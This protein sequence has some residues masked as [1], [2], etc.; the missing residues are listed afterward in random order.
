MPEW[1]IRG[2][3]SPVI[4]RLLIYG[5]SPIDVEYVVSV[6]ERT[7]DLRSLEKLWL[8]EWEKK[9]DAY[10]AIGEEARQNS[11]PDTAREL[12]F[13]AAQCLYAAF[14]INFSDATEKQRAYA[15]FAEYYGRSIRHEEPR[16]EKIEIPLGQGA[17]LP[18]YFHRPAGDTVRACA[19]VYSGLGSCKEEMHLLCRPLVRRGVAAF[20]ADYPGNGEA[21]FER[22]LNCS[23][24][25]LENSFGRIID[26]LE[27][28]PGCEGARFGSY[29]L[30]MGGGYAH[31]AAA[32]DP[33]YRFCVTL[34]P[35]F[36]GQVGADAT[37]QWM[38]RGKWYDLQTGG[39]APEAF[40]T[41]M[42]GLEQ[43][44]LDCPFLFIHGTHD[45]WMSLERASA[46]F[47]RARGTKKKIVIDTVP[48]FSTGAAVTHTMPVGEQ[49]H[50]VK[51]VAADWIAEIVR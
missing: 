7:D 24:T 21:L 51:H 40:L 8:A 25:A 49:L 16:V 20:V 19:V 46:L 47:E 34:F 5:V 13:L 9:A 32:I 33:R 45:N 29:G 41:D 17:L 14:L 1:S 28:K 35:L 15:K 22:G 38:K 10:R 50:W 48:V 12:F 39:V 18:G 3:L 23:R 30:C 11:R 26:F 2:L 6:L 37:P 43:G 36:I 44:A 4:T 31:R 27:K 42:A